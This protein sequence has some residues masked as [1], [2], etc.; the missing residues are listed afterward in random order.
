MA[1]AHQDSRTSSG[2]WA[3]RD[4]GFG[5][6][7]HAGMKMAGPRPGRRLFVVAL[8]WVAVLAADA[9]SA[10]RAEEPKATIVGLGATT[11]QRFENDVKANPAVRRDYLAWAQGFMSGI[12]SSR[13]PGV[14]EGLDLAPGSFDLIKQLRFLEDYCARNVSLDFSDA[15]AALYKR[16]RQEGKT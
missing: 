11:C 5:I 13:P 3:A 1:V 14:D 8:S 7:P 16:L 4:T 10:L 15:V 12:I 9:G 6:E 2:R